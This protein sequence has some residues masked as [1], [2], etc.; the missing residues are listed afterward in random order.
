M[1]LITGLRCSDAVVLASDSQVT[2]EGDLKTEAQKLYR[3][4]HRI[5]WGTAG[6]VAAAQAI[7]MRFKEL[8]L[9]SDPDRD[10]GRKGVKK[11]MLAAAEDMKG[12]DGQL[13]G[14]RFMGLF[15]WYS[16]DERRH[17][18]LR[19]M[20][21]GV[22]E[23][24]EQGYGAVGSSEELARFAFFGFSSS[25]FLEYETLPLEAAKMLAHTVTDDAITA[26]ARGVHGPVQLA[27]VT[28]SDAHILEESALKPVQDTA[29]AFKMHQ[30]DFLKR[31]EGQPDNVT[32]GLVPGEGGG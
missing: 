25:G 20:S 23:L 8:I 7:E 11:V 13:A 4:P 22:V 15:T 29:A 31:A 17:H 19:A 5:I 21:D 14:G 18:L 16:R 10:S 12:P 2:V 9:D 6:P 26:S 28:G 3:S 27:V 30:A 1:T 24:Q 32:S